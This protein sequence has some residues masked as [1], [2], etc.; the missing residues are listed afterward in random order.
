LKANCFCFLGN[1]GIKR[2]GTEMKTMS[3]ISDVPK[4]SL[5]MSFFFFP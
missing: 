2:R 3:N 1:D 4:N 5:K